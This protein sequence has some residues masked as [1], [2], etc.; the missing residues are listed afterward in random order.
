MSSYGKVTDAAR[1]AA[2]SMGA[3]ALMFGE[4]MRRLAK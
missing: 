2:D 3:E 4:L 1:N